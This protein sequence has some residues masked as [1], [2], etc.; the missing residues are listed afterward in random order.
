MVKN[1]MNVNGVIH[2]SLIIK[3]PVK[4]SPMAKSR[5]I[6]LLCAHLVRTDG[7]EGSG[8]AGLHRLYMMGQSAVG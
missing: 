1:E 4:S 6:I 2:Q 7:M 8:L 5:S 3:E